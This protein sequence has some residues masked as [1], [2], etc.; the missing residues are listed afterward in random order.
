MTNGA[1]PSAWLPLGVDDF[2]G[3]RAHGFVYVDKTAL[4]HAFASRPKAKIFLIR[5]RR[6]GKSLLVS[7]LASLFSRGLRDF[8]GLA[9]EKLWK[10][11]ATYPVVRLDFSRINS[12][13]NA[14][15]FRSL[16]ESQLRSAFAPW[17][18]LMRRN[19]ALPSPSS[20]PSG[21]IRSRKAPSCS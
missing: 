4:I 14:G 20:F 2:P 21:F 8:K 1:D 10:E 19:P 9:I 16:L 3:L 6:F 5:P 17:G 12:F 11:S 18:S 15:E 13:E 7:T